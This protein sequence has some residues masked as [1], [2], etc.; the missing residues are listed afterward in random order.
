M[1]RITRKSKAGFERAKV[2]GKGLRVAVVVSRFNEAITRRL[3][4]G[5]RGALLRNGVA[6]SHVME[7]SVAGAWELPLAIRVLA[8]KHDFD[9]FVALGCVVRGET[10]HYRYVAGEAA[11]GL[12]D[13]SL[14]LGV[15][16]G[17][18]LLTTDTVKQAIN[19]AGG[20]HGNKGEDAALAALEMANLI[21]KPAR[22]KR[23]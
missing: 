2:D 3:A 13:V 18:G 20:K 17:F 11:R 6:A 14:A 23:K 1:A 7:V 12:A 4:D 9:A 15:P 19:R 16:V 10:D 21:R 8:E 5:A 22:G